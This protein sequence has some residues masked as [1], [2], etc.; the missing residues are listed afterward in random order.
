MRIF[1]YVCAVLLCVLLG[2][3]G[4][5]ALMTSVQAES[6]DGTRAPL[7]WIKAQLVNDYM[8]Y[9]GRQ[10]ESFYIRYPYGTD[11]FLVATVPAGKRFIVTDIV[12][13]ASVRLSNTASHSQPTLFVGSDT[14]GNYVTHKL[15]SGIVYEPGEEI[16]LWAANGGG[17]T[18]DPHVTLSGYYVN[19]AQPMP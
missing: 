12:A 18:N 16:H 2:F 5:L 7:Y 1:G 11:T 9:H 4:S 3:A 17:S 15:S 10:I 8:Q 13:R 19:T 6:V 14:D